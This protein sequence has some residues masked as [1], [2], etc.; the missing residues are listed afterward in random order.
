M[1]MKELARITLDAKQVKQACELFVES[2]INS[3]E[4]QASASVPVGTLVTI[5]VSK[6]RAPR[7]SKVA[8]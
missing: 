4:E 2:R 8:A 7:K 5:S 6:K 3:A 1:A